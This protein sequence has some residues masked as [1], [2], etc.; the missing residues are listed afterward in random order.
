MIVAEGHRTQTAEQDRAKLVLVV[1]DDAVMRELMVATVERGGHR[2]LIAC[3][4]KE[5][6]ATARAHHPDV[7]LLDLAMPKLDGFEVCRQLKSDP[8]T[9]PI[10]VVVVTALSRP[11]DRARG[12]AAGAD[13]YVTKPFHP[14]ALLARL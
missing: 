2:V 14:R 11:E 8:A 9:S 13:D 10:R 3:D 5:A 7:V 4:G 6:V 1:D 12:E